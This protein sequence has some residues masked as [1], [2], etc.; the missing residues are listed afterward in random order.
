MDL[1]SKLMEFLCK[2]FMVEAAEIDLDVSLVDQG[3]IDS[4]GLI[5]ISAFIEEEL[6]VRIAEEQITR[7]NFGSFNKIISFMQTL[8]SEKH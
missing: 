5:E 1:K 3:I 8:Q 7:A 6:N 2:N 4:F